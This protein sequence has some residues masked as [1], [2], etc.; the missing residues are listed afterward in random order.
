MH[1]CVCFQGLC[2]KPRFGLKHQQSA[3]SECDRRPP[4][5]EIYLHHSDLFCQQNYVWG[6]S[7]IHSLMF[8]LKEC[9]MVHSVYSLKCDHHSIQLC[10]S[11]QLVTYPD[12]WI[13]GV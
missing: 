1:V 5:Y 2:V 8:F 9:M 12:G 10:F 4:G 3:F 6:F 13:Y 7:M 11:V